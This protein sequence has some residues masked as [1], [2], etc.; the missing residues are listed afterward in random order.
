MII[1][2]CNVDC[3]KVA[4]DHI[5]VASPERLDT[6]MARD[7]VVYGVAAELIVRQNAL[8]LQQPERVGF[9]DGF[10][11]PRLGADRAVALARTL[12]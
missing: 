5:Q 4:T 2:A 1:K 6:A 9:D 8:S 7:E 3:V 12:G 11:V 10:P